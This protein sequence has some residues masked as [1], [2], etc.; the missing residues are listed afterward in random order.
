M[1][2]LKPWR[3]TQDAIGEHRAIYELIQQQDAEGA[4]RAMRSHVEKARIRMLNAT[5]DT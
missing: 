1:A 3:R 2:Q 4:R 5:P